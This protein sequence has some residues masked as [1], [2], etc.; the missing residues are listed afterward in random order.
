MVIET[1][2]GNMPVFVFQLL[3]DVR[4]GVDRVLNGTTEYTGME[5]LF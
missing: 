1:G 3:Y 4:Q 2:N 5:I